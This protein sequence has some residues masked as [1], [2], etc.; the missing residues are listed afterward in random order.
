[1]NEQNYQNAVEPWTPFDTICIGEGMASYSGCQWY[2]TFAALAVEDKVSLF[3][4]RNR[5]QAGVA[6]TNMDS[7]SQM[8]F[9]FD[10][11]SIGIEMSAP[12]FYPVTAYAY[13]G[14]TLTGPTLDL[15][16][17]AHALFAG[18]ILKHASVRL[19]VQQDE[20]LVNT[21]LGTP[22]GGGIT[23]SMNVNAAAAYD[24]VELGGVQ[25]FNNGIPDRTNRFKFPQP[26][27]IPRNA[28]F[29]VEIKFSTYARNLLAKLSGPGRVM[30]QLAPDTTW[31]LDA[32]TVP[33]V[34][35]IRCTLFGARM[36]QQRNELHF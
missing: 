14:D 33:A 16:S 36:V 5:A 7:N 27:S 13:D 9:A 22:A 17:H 32:A 15:S 31:N 1:M 21:V 4:V 6:Y 34:C 10:C 2:N 28:I 18:E 8:P 26:I 12:M 19:Q 11:Y 20:K 30:I 29:N 23:G 24:G 3:N 35:L 25:A